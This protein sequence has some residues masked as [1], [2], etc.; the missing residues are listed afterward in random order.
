[1]S[2]WIAHV[3]RNTTFQPSRGRARRGRVAAAI[4][5]AFNSVR[6]AGAVTAGALRLV[7]ALVGACH[8]I[9]DALG[10]LEER[11][12]DRD[13]DARQARCAQRLDGGAHPFARAASVFEVR[14]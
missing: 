14:L 8:Q 1:M 5:L 7:E 10:F 9:R 2:P 12:A 13:G 11:H 6:S 4:S 3:S